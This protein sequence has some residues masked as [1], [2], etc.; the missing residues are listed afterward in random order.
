MRKGSRLRMFIL[1]FGLTLTAAVL[2]VATLTLADDIGHEAA[3]RLVE[4]G[5]ILGLAEVLEQVGQ[6]VPGKLLGTE[7]EYED[8][9]IVY[10]IKIL[11]PGGRLQEVEVDAATGHIISIED[12]D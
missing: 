12:D 1:R 9:R 11:R 8:G 3:R 7:L 10:E 2:P 5:K 4:E 6:K